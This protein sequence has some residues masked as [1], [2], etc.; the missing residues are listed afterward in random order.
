M[1]P[2]RHAAPSRHADDLVRYLALLIFV[3][4]LTGIGALQH[5]SSPKARPA[6]AATTS[7]RLTSQVQPRVVVPPIIPAAT[8]RKAAKKPVVTK[9]PVVRKP[10]IK[11]VRW[12]PTG[13]GM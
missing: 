12:L 10:A 13:T 6:A 11:V 8:I 5:A 4:L 1:P 3:V 2:P 9:K 7:I